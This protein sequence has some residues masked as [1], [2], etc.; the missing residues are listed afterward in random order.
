MAAPS[1]VLRSVRDKTL[2]Q[3]CPEPR[4]A[5]EIT[6]DDRQWLFI[7]SAGNTQPLL[8]DGKLNPNPNCNKSWFN[9]IPSQR[10]KDEVSAAMRVGSVLV[11]AG[12]DYDE[13]GTYMHSPQSVIC[14]DGDEGCLW[15]RMEFRTPV[16]VC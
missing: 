15:I 12:Y 8:S 9:K 14:P 7:V 3:V 2:E 10:D 4:E 11:A 13:D 1:G 5:P 6:A 16:A